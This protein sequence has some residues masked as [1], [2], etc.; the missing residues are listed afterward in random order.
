MHLDE[1]RR[2]HAIILG[3]ETRILEIKR[4]VNELLA[5]AGKPPRY[6]SAVAD[7]GTEER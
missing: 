7:A 3:R 4:E 1:L 2:W 6:P 5:G